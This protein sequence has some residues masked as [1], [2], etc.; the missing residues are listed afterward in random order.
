MNLIATDLDR[1]L[2]PNGN[3]EYDNSL[4]QLKELIKDKGLRLMFVTGRNVDQVRDGMERYDPPVPE[5]L[6]AEVGTRIYSYTDGTFTE[7]QSYIDFIRDNTRGWDADEIR[8]RLLTIDGLELQEPHNQ[9]RFKVSFFIRDLDRADEIKKQAAEMLPDITPDGEITYSVDETVGIG[10]LDVLPKR[11]NKLEAL[12][13]LRKRLG[14]T[15]EEMIYFGDSGNDLVPLTSGY[16]AVLVR[17]AADEVKK[18]ARR[19]AREKG[20]AD[21]VYIAQGTADLNGNYSSGIIEGLH[22]FGI[23]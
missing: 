5:Y 8:E 11:A 19:T 1:T 22:F 2:F 10:L 13:F 18:E 16:R 17:N 23:S 20:I 4:P 9:N 12:E 15:A 7:D 21:C 14:L 6:I 3:Q